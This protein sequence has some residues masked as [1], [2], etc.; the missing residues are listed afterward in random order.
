MTDYLSYIEIAFYPDCINYWLRFGDPDV[1]YDLDRTRSLALF[2]PNKIFGYVRWQSDE[3]G[4]ED[5]RIAVVQTGAPKQS[6]CRCPGVWPGGEILLSVVG[7]TR[8]KRVLTQ[9]DAL[10]TAG[11]HPCD[12]S[13]FYYR[14]LHSRIAVGKTVRAYSSTQHAAHVAARAVLA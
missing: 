12:V 7:S 10:K 14:H 13:P 11:F 8:V 6:L 1:G 2:K 9:F 5:W 3:Y 4:A